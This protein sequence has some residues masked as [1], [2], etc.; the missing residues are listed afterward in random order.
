MAFLLHAEVKSPQAPASRLL[1]RHP[2]APEASNS[3]EQT[4]LAQVS[5]SKQKLKRFQQQRKLVHEEAVAAKERAMALSKRASQ[6]ELKEAVLEEEADMDWEQH[7]H[8]LPSTDGLKSDAE[9]KGEMDRVNHHR[10]VGKK[11]VEVQAQIDAE[12]A[13]F[14]A[15]QEKKR[16]DEERRRADEYFARLKRTEQEAREEKKRLR[17]QMEKDVFAKLER[18][19]MD[20]ERNR[21][22]SKKERQKILEKKEAEED[23]VIREETKRLQLKKDTFDRD[24]TKRQQVL[25]EEEAERIAKLEEAKRQW[26]EQE[27]ERLA[28]EE[29]ARQRFKAR[30]KHFASQRREQ[31]LSAELRRLHTAAGLEKILIAKETSEANANRVKEELEAKRNVRATEKFEEEKKNAKEQQGFTLKFW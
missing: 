7:H 2:G 17:K 26:R 16:K 5:E 27:D 4:L 3:Q 11:L 28:I 10:Q 1:G 12:V 29:S 24:L 25:M 31:A 8:R 6:T 19:A 23:F 21:I 18:K 13:A 20:A 15:A 30:S 14:S 22:I 9:K